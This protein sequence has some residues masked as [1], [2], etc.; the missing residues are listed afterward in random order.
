[1]QELGYNVDH[2]GASGYKEVVQE[3]QARGLIVEESVIATWEIERTP[4]ELLQ[5]VVERDRS[6]TWQV[7]DD[8]FAQSVQQLSIYAQEQSKSTL[9]VPEHI[10]ITFKVARTISAR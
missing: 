10:P 8:V 9:D 3:L 7:P 6:N 5:Q 1:M 2:R 4:R